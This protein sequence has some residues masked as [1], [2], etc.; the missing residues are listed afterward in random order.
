MI[1]FYFFIKVWRHNFFVLLPVLV[2]VNGL[3]VNAEERIV[4]IKIKVKGDGTVDPATNY[5]N[6]K[7]IEFGGNSIDKGISTSDKAHT[8]SRFIEFDENL[9]SNRKIDSNADYMD[10]ESI[11]LSRYL[12]DNGVIVSDEQNKKLIDNEVVVLGYTSDKVVDGDENPVRR[13][14]TEPDENQAIN[15]G[16]NVDLSVGSDQMYK[17]INGVDETAETDILWLLTALA[18]LEKNLGLATL[19]FN[20]GF[21]VLQT[22]DSTVNIGLNGHSY[23]DENDLFDSKSFQL[24]WV[25]GAGAKL[26]FVPDWVLQIK[27]SYIN[28]GE[29]TYRSCRAMENFR[30]P[31]SN[32]EQIGVIELTINREF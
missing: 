16:G 15:L 26:P 21:A 11:E 19:R 32:I 24:G 20:S 7:F 28:L 3:F 6:D 14:M 13:G 27:A 12:I 31:C 8:K 4:Q 2:L 18:V 29:D 10:N 5:I 30:G 25:I 22:S 23:S 1:S 17:F 9:T